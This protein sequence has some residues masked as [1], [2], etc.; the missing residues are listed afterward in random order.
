MNSE[1]QQP[2]GLVVKTS[3]EIASAASSSHAKAL[4]EAQF[5]MAIQRP[6]N[7][8]A[9]RERILSACRRP[10]FAVTAWYAKPQGGK[11]IRGPSIRF[12]EMAVQA[13]GNISVLP[14]IVYEDRERMVMSI[15]VIDLETNTAYSDP[16]TLAKTVERKNGEG[17]EIIGERVNTSGEKVFI[18]LATEDEMANK[19]NS[20]KSKSI[21]NSGLRLVP[22][23]FIEEAEQVVSETL[24][25]GGGDSSLALK[26]M[27]D[28]FSAIGVKPTELEKYLGHS[29]DAVS[30]AELKDLREVYQTL[31]DGESKWSDYVEGGQRKAASREPAAPVPEAL[32]AKV[33]EA[34]TSPLPQ[35]SWAHG[36]ASALLVAGFTPAEYAAEISRQVG[37]TLDFA[38]IIEGTHENALCTSWPQ[39]IDAMESAR[40]KGGKK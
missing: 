34:D 23:D 7:L 3:G 13:M 25:G 19:I 15:Q 39:M 8:L 29:L 4:I 30:P 14:S 10:G 20:A 33:V 1:T 31:K 27:A 32:R 21:R 5:V 35:E 11:K 12:A 28:A 18:V 6:R 16:V 24:E 2:L 38:D 9:A 22:Q 40:K 17:R 36:V 37:E 26:K